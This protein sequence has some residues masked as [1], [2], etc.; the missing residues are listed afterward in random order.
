MAFLDETGLAALWS[1]IKAEDAKGA[2]IATGSYV[3]TGKYGEANA[4]TLTFDFEPK[5][6]LVICGGGLGFETELDLDSESVEVST[7]NHT[8]IWLDGMTSASVGIYHS[9]SVKRNG[10]SISY[11]DSHD[12]LLNYSS[13]TYRYVAI[14]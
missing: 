13:N 12:P 8:L 10:N 14:G 7:D 1:L 6:L 3:G 9:L 2:K 11:Y 5:F 4:V